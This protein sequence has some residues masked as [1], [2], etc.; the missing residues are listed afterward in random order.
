MISKKGVEGMIFYVKYIDPSA[1]M[2]IT[3]TTS[4][5]VYL[6]MCLP[7]IFQTEQQ[8]NIQNKV[9][10][11]EQSLSEKL[12]KKRISLKCSKLLMDFFFSVYRSRSRRILAEAG[13]A[14]K[15]RL[16]LHL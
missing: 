3:R 16:R 10:S 5:P 7:C 11:V 8:K 9:S 13:A 2:H 15:G 6:P 4:V 1:C 12:Y 14:L